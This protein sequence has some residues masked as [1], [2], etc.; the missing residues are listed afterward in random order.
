MFIRE[1]LRKT[2][3]RCWQF[4]KAIFPNFNNK[5]WE[6]ALKNADKELVNLL[7]QLGKAEKAHTLRVIELIN[8]DEALNVEI[9]KELSDFALIHDIGKAITK[10]S[11]FFK[12]LGIFTVPISLHWR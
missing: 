5:L 3:Y 6:E 2:L 1:I 12:P 7:N 8:R 10:P 11:L 9:K 4:Y